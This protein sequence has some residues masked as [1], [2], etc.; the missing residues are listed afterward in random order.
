MKKKR[1]HK[2]AQGKEEAVLGASSKATK[3]ERRFRELQEKKMLEFQKKKHRFKNE[4]SHKVD[5]NKNIGSDGGEDNP[6]EI[7]LAQQIKMTDD[8][9]IIEKL[10]DRVRQ[11]EKSLEQSRSDY[12][13]AQADLE[14]TRIEIATEKQKCKR[15]QEQS[16]KVAEINEE[17][18]RAEIVSRKQEEIDAAVD[19][20]RKR[21]ELEFQSRMNEALQEERSKSE[22]RLQEGLEKGMWVDL[23]CFDS[24]IFVVCIYLYLQGF[25]SE[26]E[27]FPRELKRLSSLF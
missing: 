16:E 27:T 10:Q 3:A 19:E 18:L 21:N 26:K 8:Y 20:E 1:G 13:S 12:E 15:L 17:K 5:I 7:Q 6:S 14:S 9:K 11:L 22:T 2:K 23:V 25:F 24:T 4:Q